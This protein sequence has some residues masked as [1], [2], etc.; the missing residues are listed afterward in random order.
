MIYLQNIGTFGEI[1]ASCYYL[2]ID[3]T[4]IVIDAGMHPK[5]DGVESLP[6]FDKLEDKQVDYLI[7][8]HAHH[9]HIGSVPY[10]VRRHPHVKILSTVNTVELAILSM[11]NSSRIMKEYVETRT[12]T[13][14]QRSS[15]MP[16]TAE[17][18][19]YLGRMIE[20]LEYE[21]PYFL[22]GF[23]HKSS[24]DIELVLYDSGHIMGSASLL[25][26][27]KGFSFFFTGDINFT[28][29]TILAGAQI[30]R[31]SVDVL[32]S[33]ATLGST[34]LQGTW[35]EEEEKLAK[36][37]NA[38]LSNGGSALIPV[39]AIGKSQELLA[40][41]YDMMIDHKIPISPIYVAGMSNKVNR[42][43][44]SGRFRGSRVSLSYDLREIPKITLKDS[45]PLNEIFKGKSIVLATSGMMIEDTK[46]FRL[47]EDF[48]KN[49]K[50]GIFSVGYMDP[51]TPGYRVSNAKTGDEI[52]FKKGK[53]PVKVMCSIDKF[54]F[55]AH[56][57]REDLVNFVKQVKAKR[58]ILTHGDNDAVNELG[59]LMLEKYPGLSLTVAEEQRI[60]LRED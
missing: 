45:T 20:G 4:G 51:D 19:T 22:S 60:V 42:L 50:C 47:A 17:E 24:E 2:Y 49:S 39:F 46:S 35:K 38:V 8:T 29:Q 59:A 31:M 48:L 37:L 55:S 30:P 40:S 53:P 9:D 3:G 15:L 52:E 13:A 32:L 12:L 6:D 54:R 58:V 5:K 11:V 16:Y 34:A 14:K 41:I 10:L 43:Y 18:T 21:K 25:I 26:K 44:D 27:H 28:P 57:K 56:A 1:G 23:K 36:A 33:E 7:I